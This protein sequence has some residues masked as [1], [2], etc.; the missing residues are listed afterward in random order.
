MGGRLILNLTHSFFP[1]VPFP[2]V[3]LV[4]ERIDNHHYCFYFIDI[5]S[6]AYGYLY[7]LHVLL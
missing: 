1:E 4:I 2:D 5:S 6:F 3:T 7:L